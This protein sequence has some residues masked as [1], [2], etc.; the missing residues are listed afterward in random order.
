MRIGEH[1]NVLLTQATKR[2]QAA[3]PLLPWPSLPTGCGPV[4]LASGASGDLAAA[5][6]CEHWTVEPDSLELAWGAARRFRLTPCVAGPDVTDGL[7]RL[8]SRWREH[9]A[10]VPGTG[11]ADTAA[12]VTWPSRDIGGVAAL[13]RHGL[14]PTDVTAARLAGRAGRSPAARP[15]GDATRLADVLSLDSVRIRRAEAADLEVV[16]E[17]GLEVIR[18]DAYFSSVNERPSTAEALRCEAAGWLASP[19]PWTW[20]AERRGRPVGLLSAERPPT[21]AWIAP[22]TAA[23]P[24]AYVMFMFVAPDERG[25]G[26]GAALAEHFHREADAS[27]IG[28]TLLHYGALNPLSVPFWSRQ[29]YRPLWTTWEVAPASAIR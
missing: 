15:N 8:L 25:S 3:D 27:G 29:D 24:V 11:D 4:L 28:V 26:V 10:E 9:L 14:A 13:R 16:T 17:L 22:L 2:W 1:M 5:G 12:V 21:A 23:A 19:S 18:Y 7:D 6:T 20:L